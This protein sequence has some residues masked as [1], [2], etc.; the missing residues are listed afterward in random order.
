MPYVLLIVGAVLFLTAV[1][2][3]TRQLGS[4]LVADIFGASGYLYWAVAVLVIGAIGYIKPLRGLTNVFLLLLIVVLFL[5]AG[6]GF[7]DRFSAALK[8][9]KSS[10]SN[11][12]SP[13]VALPDLHLSEPFTG[14]I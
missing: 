9:I 5:K 10:A 6:T 11:A 3:T 8:D 13:E 2:G 12:G 4:M 7:F 1:Q 14:P